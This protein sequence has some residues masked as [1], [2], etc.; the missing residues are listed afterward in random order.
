M[1][2]RESAITDILQSEVNLLPFEGI[3]ISSQDYETEEEDDEL[4]N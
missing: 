2:A 4:L 3:I 1:T